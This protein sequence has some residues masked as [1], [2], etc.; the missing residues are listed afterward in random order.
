MIKNKEDYLYYLEADL[1]SRKLTKWKP[2]M[3]Y[4]Y[5]ELH[6]QRQLRKVE[7]LKTKKKKNWFYKLLYNYHERKL[8]KM[9][10]NLGYYIHPGNFG[11][12]LKIAH[13][14]SVIV[15]KRVR[16]GKN[17]TIHSAVGIGRHKNQVPTIGDNVYIGPGVKIYGGIKIGNNVMIGANSVVN[18]DVPD[19]VTVAGAPAKI[20]STNTSKGKII[21]GAGIAKKRIKARKAK[22]TISK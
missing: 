1:A 21:N 20:I 18:K 3:K 2:S 7:Y 8:Q 15:N 17:C 6:Y 13:Y 4:K 5:P 11:P 19:N 22:V 9:G 16:V 14:G 12:G 10:I